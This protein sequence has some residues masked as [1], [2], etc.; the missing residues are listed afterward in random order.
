[1]VEYPYRHVLVTRGWVMKAYEHERAHSY[2]H[3]HHA[4][5]FKS[6]S[7]FQS[8]TTAATIAVFVG[9]VGV[10]LECCVVLSTNLL[11]R[12]RHGRWFGANANRHRSRDHRFGTTPE[13][14]HPTNPGTSLLEPSRSQCPHPDDDG[15]V[16]RR[17]RAAGTPTAG[18]SL[19]RFG[20]SYSESQTARI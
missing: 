12:D 14:S 4:F 9:L 13:A 3:S 1:M 11:A 17:S 10:A 15:F 6:A 2:E 20:K 8:L 16:R 7:L 5:D 18:C 19:P